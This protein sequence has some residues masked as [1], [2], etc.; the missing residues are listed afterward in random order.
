MDRGVK[1]KKSKQNYRNFVHREL[2]SILP[3]EGLQ[4]RWIY[5]FGQRV[6]NQLSFAFVSI[7]LVSILPIYPQ[8]TAAKNTKTRKG[9]GKPSLLAHC[10]L[11]VGVCSFCAEGGKITTSLWEQPY[12]L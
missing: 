1:N 11:L 4:L 12:R 6:V 7:Y 9:S 5:L 2:T 8:G 3:P 10:A